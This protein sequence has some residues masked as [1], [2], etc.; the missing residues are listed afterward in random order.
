M[1]NS[2]HRCRDV[3]EKSHKDSHGRSGIVPAPVRTGFIYLIENEEAGV[4]KIGFSRSYPQE[5][6]Q[7]MQTANHQVIRLRY[8]IVGTRRDEG[9]IHERLAALKIRGEWFR[10]LDYLIELFDILYEATMNMDDEQEPVTLADI[11]SAF[12]EALNPSPAVLER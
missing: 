5:R 10:D 6:V 8:T 2:A 3:N 12:A 7:K 9:Q 4:G 1:E 11:E